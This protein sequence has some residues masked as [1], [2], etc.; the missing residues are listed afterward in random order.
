M[1]VC[2][3]RYIASYTFPQERGGCVGSWVLSTGSKPQPTGSSFRN[4]LISKGT[5]R[6][7]LK[8]H[9]QHFHTFLLYSMASSSSHL[10]VLFPT[11]PPHSPT[12]SAFPS[13]FPSTLPSTYLL[14]PSSHRN[15]STL[16]LTPLPLLLFLLL[17]SYTQHLFFIPSQ[18]H[19]PGHHRLSILR[20]YIIFI[21]LEI[22]SSL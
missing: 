4:A 6:Y 13:F 1:Y 11:P 14:Q 21:L 10:L 15:I 22:L 8:W 16:P 20:Q 5:S 2:V 3:Q 7:T 18:L 17:H 9:F 12:P 19:H